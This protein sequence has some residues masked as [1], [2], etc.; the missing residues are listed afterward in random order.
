MAVSGSGS[1]W[2]DFEITKDEVRNITEALKKEEFR[3]L[4]VDYIEEVNDPENRKKY[5]EEITI[6]EKE[7]GY[8]VDFINPEPG[9]V[10]KTSV[11]GTKKAFINVCKSEKIQKP[12]SSRASKSGT[13]GVNWSLPY[14]QVHPRDDLDKSGKRCLV[15][16]VVFH[17]DTHDLA[18]KSK[19]FR[20]MLNETAL[21]AVESNFGVKLD[22]KNLRFPK[23]KYKGAV[24]NSILRK[25]SE[26]P[27]ENVID[28]HLRNIN[29]P[30][31]VPD[32]N[33][34]PRES[35][36]RDTN[37]STGAKQD[38]DR[39]PYT[40]PTYLIK[41]R[42]PVDM[43]EFIND[44]S[45]KIN[46]AIPKELVIEV[47]L[48]LLS[49][50]SDVVLDVT[51][52][53]L[54][55]LSEK[56]A[57]Y[58]LELKLPYRVYE[59]SGNAKFDKDQRKLIITL[60][61]RRLTEKRVVDICRE[62]SGVESD[63]SYQTPEF[64]SGDDD[65]AESESQKSEEN[66]PLEESELVPDK[67]VE[68]NRTNMLCVKSFLDPDKHYLLPTFTC[69]VFEDVIAFTLHVKNVDPSSVVHCSLENDCGVA[70]KFMSIGSG[71]FP[72]YYAFC[73]KFPNGAGVGEN[74]VNIETWD[75]NVVMQMQLV[76]C[77]HVPAEYFAG[78]DEDS[79]LKHDIPDV[80]A[81]AS[82][83]GK[84]RKNACHQEPESYLQAEVTEASDT[85]L[86]LEI[87]LDERNHSHGSSDVDQEELKV[88]DSDDYNSDN[89][90]S[91]PAVN[92]KWQPPLVKS[93]TFSESSGEDLNL[94]P[95]KGIL[96][97]PGRVSRSLS[98]SS[99]DDY[100]WSSSLD[101]VGQSAGSDICIPEEEESGTEHKKTVRFND[102]VSEK[103]Y[104]NNSSILGQRKKNQR[105]IRNK[106]RAQERRASESEN[107]EGETEKERDKE[108]ESNND[109]E[110][111]EFHKQCEAKS[112]MGTTDRQHNEGEDDAKPSLSS[113]AAVQCQN[114]A[115]TSSEQST[116]HATS[117]VSHIQLANDLV[118]QLSM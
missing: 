41:H 58:K 79:L 102:D 89:V 8:D 71:H 7:R 46:A 63:T 6:L 110:N 105:K 65:G 49:S 32:V 104:R 80:V 42:N 29:Y 10:I 88:G 68:N 78:P 20:N 76:A 23:L 92:K 24:S 75:N 106:K 100:S 14:S 90:S 13:K 83:L 17:P 51:E 91:V 35:A 72:V 19:Q 50:T 95:R 27:P 5:Q 3:K 67:C 16:D 117:A 96:K 53:S 109:I 40:T 26:N 55:L 62:D 81:V 94:S 98:E 70:V 39:T 9:Y 37:C 36:K 21:D 73:V 44:K 111:D 2:D 47:D 43:Q 34:K 113:S 28:D 97:H 57:K 22:R 112:N 74:N 30:Y 59:D 84:L 56:H 85:S 60:P 38:D 108:L 4:L 12:T 114:K 64:S 25:K 1:Q 48:P 33:A 93:R 118:H 45:A 66:F 101:I 107:S 69:N 82:S 61:V 11:D 31:A 52:E 15:Y 115:S 99:V 18:N 77:D 116:V 87:K 86:L 54:S 103:I